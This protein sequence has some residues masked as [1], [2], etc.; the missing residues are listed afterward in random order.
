MTTAR[1]VIGNYNYSSWSLRAWLAAR[2]AGLAVEVTRVALDVPGFKTELYSHSPTG[3]VP[4]LIVE[5][6]S[7]WDSLAIG[8]YL[9]ELTP[10]LWPQDAVHRRHAYSLAAEIH[11]GFPLLRAAM[12]MNCRAN[13]RKVAVDAALEAE[14]SRVDA[15]F[16]SCTQSRPG[17]L[18]GDFSIADAMYAPVV[19]RLHT[20]G[21]A[22]S[23]P[24]KRYVEHVLDDPHMREWYE[25]AAAEPEL[26]DSEEVGVAE[27]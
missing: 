14:L 18:F 17:W 20:Y 4:V 19:S 23:A 15:L 9:A 24:S 5:G 27:T 12:P 16:A 13:G 6:Q 3:R 26:I 8:L 25:R 7:I 11:A 10:S 21:V 22:L 1:L 2:H